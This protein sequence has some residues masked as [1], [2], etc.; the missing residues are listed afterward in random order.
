MCFILE[1]MKL[2][3]SEYSGTCRPKSVLYVCGKNSIRS[4]IA[5]AL[6]RKMFPDIY[7]A[8]AG[9]V[10]GERDPFA[11]C[12]ISEDGLSL[13]AHNPRGLEEL[14]DGFFDLVITLT[15][16]AHHAVLD[17]MRSFSVDVEYWPTSDPALTMGSREQILDAY[18]N[19]RETL[20]QRIFE[21]F[22]R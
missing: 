6:T 9:V 16:Q 12:V 15:P 11:A 4:P 21:R 2:V 10:K 19:I 13:D 8:S 3:D 14:S 20:K 18:R 22:N 17:E 5:E 7:V 1:G